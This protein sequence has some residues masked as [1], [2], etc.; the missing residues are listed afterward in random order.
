[1]IDHKMLKA[2]IE[3]AIRQYE[4]A[5]AEF[6]A[7]IEEQGLGE[8]FAAFLERTERDII[9]RRIV[10][11]WII[12]LICRWTKSYQTVRSHCWPVDRRTDCSRLLPGAN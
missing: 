4:K 7:F 10:R 11:R 3:D 2:K 8:E 5:I 6:D 1:M 12:H 9:E